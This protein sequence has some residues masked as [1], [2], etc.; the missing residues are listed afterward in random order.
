MGDFRPSGEELMQP[1]ETL[2]K[3]TEEAAREQGAEL[4]DVLPKD[5]SERLED[6]GKS[7]EAALVESFGSKEVPKELT[8]EMDGILNEAAGNIRR[9]GYVEEIDDELT[10]KLR[11]LAARTALYK[12]QPADLAVE[13]VPEEGYRLS[14]TDRS[15]NRVE[16]PMSQE[17]QDLLFNMEMWADQH[18]QFQNAESFT[19]ALAQARES[20]KDL[21]D[22]AARTG[23]VRAELY[24]R[25]E[26]FGFTREQIDDLA[27]LAEGEEALPELVPKDKEPGTR[28][29]EIMVETWKKYLSGEEKTKYLKMAGAIVGVGAAEGLAPALLRYMMDSG[30]AQ[31]A[32]LFA[33]GYIG[34]TAGLGWVRKKLSLDLDKFIN[35]VAERPGGLNERLSQDLV[36]QPGEKMAGTDQ[37]GRLMTAMRRGQSAFREVLSSM[38]KSTAPAIASATVG[39]GMMLATDWRL[40]ALSLASAPIAIAIA[41]RA[42]KRAEPILNE[43]FRNEDETAQ[44]VEEQINAH[45]EIVLSGMRD[46]MGPRLQGLIKKQNELTHERGKVWA[47]MDFQNGSVLN[48]A[49]VAGLTTAGVALRGLGVQE[50]GKIVAALVY[51]GMFRNSFDT[52]VRQQARMLESCAS[53]VE[54]EEVFNGYADEEKAEDAERV[55]ASELPD[56][57]IDL[58]GVDL[59]I[60]GRKLIDGASFSIPAGGVARIEGMSGHGKTT[61]T[62]LMAGYYRPTSGEVRIGGRRAEEIKRT[63]PESVY[64]HLAYLSQHPYVFDSGNLRDN[65]RFGNPDA[66]DEDMAEVIRE[67]GLE[68]RF[69]GEKG[70]DLDGKVVGLSG[71][72]KTRVGLARTLLK[73]RSQKNGGIVFLDQPTED[74]D[75]ETEAE[76]SDILVREKRKHPKVTFVVVS[77][78]PSFIENLKKERGGEPGLA[79]QR[80]K[81][82]EGRVEQ[83][84]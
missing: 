11:L 47:G 57:A 80:I 10:D 51:S 49:I 8:A 70:I 52:I 54:M 84:G 21:A 40:G 30:S 32:A 7:V 38:A 71:G 55:S 68:R 29:L 26:K 6:Y 31:T 48:P 74:L 4:R 62:K 28:Q 45:M 18:N 43:S 60:G 50:S 15:G 23:A 44:E 69:G 67:L 64:S 59:E 3:K 27:I 2:A 14:Y 42:Q 78:R 83:N 73:I 53:I 75:E 66:K 20:A 9:E 17:E 24:K 33:A 39:F 56:Y 41:R 58:K 61:L 1:R 36:F 35:D 22:G 37:R 34:G 5:V 46:D 77:H 16:R 82:N 25:Y 72:E 81:V 63:G 65:L 19:A 13:P 76:V 12:E 79:I